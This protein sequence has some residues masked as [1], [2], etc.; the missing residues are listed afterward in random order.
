MYVITG[1]VLQRAVYQDMIGRCLEFLK[2]VG[3]DMFP[4]EDN[5]D[6]AR[7]TLNLSSVS[8]YKTNLEHFDA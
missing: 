5:N 3:F 7:L 4:E 8:S 1:I 2:H 6:D